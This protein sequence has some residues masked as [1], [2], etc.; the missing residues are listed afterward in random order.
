MPTSLVSS[1][2]QPVW[3]IDKTRLGQGLR[4][5][6]V[7]H[8]LW[9]VQLSALE[10]AQ[11]DATIIVPDDQRRASV[12]IV[13]DG[14]MRRGSYSNRFA[15]AVMGLMVYPSRF[16]G[17]LRGFCHRKEHRSISLHCQVH[18]LVDPVL[19]LA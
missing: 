8:D 12:D 5:R 15:K 19:V 11:N 17:L 1:Y 2:A 10:E 9:K 13:T 16:L 6:V 18:R 4:P 14:E 7:S 3:L